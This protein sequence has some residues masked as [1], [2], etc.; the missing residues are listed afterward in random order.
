MG[1]NYLTSEWRDR[2]N[3]GMCWAHG[4][5][6]VCRLALDTWAAIHVTY[7]PEIPASE[8]S[9]VLNRL[10]G[11]DGLRGIA[12]LAVVIYH[13]D[14]GILSGGFLGVD[15]FFVL[16]GFLITNLLLTEL[17]N[18]DGIDFK[19]FYI[20]RIRRLVPALVA[21]LLVGILISGF[22]ISDIGYAFRRDL[23]WALSFTLNWSYLFGE[24]S[25]FVNIA[26]P[27]VLQH[28]WSLAIEEQFYLVWPIALLGLHVVTRRRFPLRG[29]IVIVATLG[30]IASTL[31]MSYLSARH[32]YPIPNDP[33]RVY[34]G[35]DSHAMGLLIGAAAAALW[36]QEHLKTPVTPDRRAA[37]NLIGLSSLAVVLWSFFG[38]TELTPWIY[39][40][41]FFW[42]SVATAILAVIAAH[43]GLSFGPRLGNRILSWFGTRSY[44]MYLWHWPLFTV[45]RPGLDIAAPE[46]FVHTARLLAL[47]VISEISYRYLELP[48]RRGVIGDAISR[49]K[50]DGLPRPHISIVTGTVASVAVLIFAIAGLNNAKAPDVSILNGLGGI[51]AIDD[52]PTEAPTLAP[53]PVNETNVKPTDAQTVLAKH[54]KVVIFGD[55]VVLSGREA[56]RSEIGKL[57]I[58]AAVGRQPNEIAKRIKIRRKEDR[59]SADVVIH[60]GTNGLVTQKDLEPILNQLR[61]RRRVVVVNVQVPRVWMKATNKMIAKVIKHYPNVRLANWSAA[62]KGKRKYFAPDGVHLTKRGSRVFAKLI[63]RELNA[64]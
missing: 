21:V 15:V 51:T 56:L 5:T 36:R 24:H 64:P 1:I 54:G 2:R 59:L 50:S 25:Y 44:G 3:F 43:P 20:R 48:I 29:A 57:S 61:D 46:L 34:F 62:S 12:V 6:V 31:W 27:P 4:I 60:M 22:L 28:L 41:G 58:D 11:L 26:R 55:S 9:D 30:A 38:T 19:N 49:W 17:I 18:T 14:L 13:A 7:P 42:V 32:G 45:T 63:E 16:S 10:P 40:G 37:M 33:S 47:C 8:T 53:L 35:T 52:D 39:H 23:P